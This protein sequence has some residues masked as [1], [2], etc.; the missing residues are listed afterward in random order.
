MKQLRRDKNEVMQTLFNGY[1]SIIAVYLFGSRADGT[2]HQNSD[3]DIGIL[4]NNKVNYETAG[5][6]QMELEEKAESILSCPVDIVLLNY[7]SIVIRFKIINN[8]TVL[9]CR[10]DEKRTDFEEIVM[11]DYHDF[12]P[13][14]DAFNRDVAESI[15][16]GE[17]F[18]K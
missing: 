8:G 11:R 7:A 6:M 13:F 9:Y 3:Y 15:S 16:E 12:K 4:L 2:A 14:L 18:V 1:K 5:L 17:F 10:D